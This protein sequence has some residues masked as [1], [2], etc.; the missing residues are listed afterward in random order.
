MPR[1]WKEIATLGD[2]SPVDHGGG[3]VFKH[4]RNEYVLVYNRHGLSDLP[5]DMLQGEDGEDTELEV[6]FLELPKTYEEFLEAYGDAPWDAPHGGV[7]SSNGISPLEFVSQL[8]EMRFAKGDEFVKK[9]VYW[10]EMLLWYGGYELAGGNVNEIPA[11]QL[12]KLFEKGV[13]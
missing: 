13:F 11:Y 1:K 12:E 6:L 9:S 8:R 5:D 4:G 3:V 10:I 7:V 2:S